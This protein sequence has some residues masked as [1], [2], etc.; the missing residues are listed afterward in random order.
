ML[1]TLLPSIQKGLNKC[2]KL[3]LFTAAAA[4]EAGKVELSA[5]LREG[6]ECGYLVEVQVRED[7]GDNAKEPGW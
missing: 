4:K 6:N 3:L 5:S 2:C 7:V 1:G